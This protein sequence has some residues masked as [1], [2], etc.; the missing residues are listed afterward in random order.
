MLGSGSPMKN[1]PR[2]SRQYST[3][4]VWLISIALTGLVTGQTPQTPPPQGGGQ[5]GAGRGGQP[6]REGQERPGSPASQRPP[7]TITP[8]A[9]PPQQVQAGRDVFTAQCGFCHG[10]D[11]MGGETGPDLTRSQV[12][13]EDVR[14]DKIGPV[15]RTGRIDKNMPA[16]NLS[17]TDLA[18]VVA[19]I[20]DQKMKAESLEGNRRNVDPSDLQTGDVQAGEQYFNG[21]GGCATCHSPTGDLAGIAKKHQGLT[22]LQRM[23]NPRGRGSTPRATPT[24]IVTLP[25][26]T[27]VSGKLAYRDEFTIALTDESGW[28]R[29][30]PASQV[31]FTVNDPLAAH[32]ELLG[33][34]TDDDMHNVLAYLQTLR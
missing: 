11:A 28:H 34:Y 21:P 26:G 15:V 14:G 31:K 5:A 27:T 8:Q 16:F 30:W 19:Y 10:R 6:V 29:S 3:L 12:V 17:D 18:A 2:C 13:A 1:V 4:L 25:S 7:T 20:H 22:L 32:V 23:L 9:F 33:K 24:V